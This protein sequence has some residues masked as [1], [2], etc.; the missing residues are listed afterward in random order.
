MFGIGKVKWQDILVKI[1]AKL[2]RGTA[3]C[4]REEISPELKHWENLKLGSCTCLPLRHLIDFCHV[5]LLKKGGNPFKWSSGI[6][7]QCLHVSC[8]IMLN[9]LWNINENNW[10]LDVLG[11]QSLHGACSGHRSLYLMRG[12]EMFRWTLCG[13]VWILLTYRYPPGLSF[14]LFAHFQFWSHSDLLS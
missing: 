10:S 12:L 6:Q 4:S 5:T 3:A 2:L 14:D 8:K 1:I 11:E 7:N 9:R 13:C